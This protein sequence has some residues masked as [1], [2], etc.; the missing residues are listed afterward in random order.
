MPDVRPLAKLLA[1]EPKEAIEKVNSHV[2]NNTN[3]L[4]S[5]QKDSKKLAEKFKL[6]LDNLE[7]AL[8]ILS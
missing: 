1:S 5:L 4:E 3:N 6:T 8:E 7:T 2:L